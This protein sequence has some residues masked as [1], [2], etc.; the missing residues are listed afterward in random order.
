MASLAFAAHA[1]TNMCVKT[2]DGKVVKYDVENVTEVYYEETTETPS[3]QGVTVSGKEGIY[4]YVDLG[5]ESGTKWATYNV[6]ASKS[7]EY[8]DYFAWGETKPKEDYSWETYKWCTTVYAIDFPDTF[9]KY[10]TESDYG[11]VD[12]KNVLEAE[13]DAATANWGSAWRMPI[14]K[15]LGELLEG[16]DWEWVED[17]N[18][19]GVNGQ[20]GTSKANGATIFL[21]AAGVR[22][23]TDLY[24]AGHFGDYCS[25]SLDVSQPDCA[26]RLDFSDGTVFSDSRLRR[27]G[28]SVRA[29]LEE[30][31]EY[32]VNFYDGDSVLIESQKVREGMSA[33][34]VAAPENDGYKFVGWSDSSFVNVKENLKIYAL[35]EKNV[36]TTDQGVTVSGKVGIYTY[37]DL[38]LPSG[39]KWATYNVGATK[40]TEYGDYFAWGETKPKKD[41]NF[42]TYK[43]CKGS[44]RSMTKYCTKS[45]YGTVDNKKVL[46]AE[47]DAATANWGSAWRMPTW[48]EIKELLDGCSWE[49]VEDFNGSGVN[50]QLGTSKKNGSTIF[51]PAAVLLCD[52]NL[53]NAGGDGNYWSSSLDESYPIGAYILSFLDGFIVWDQDTRSF[54]LSVRAVLR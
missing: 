44:S 29:V 13:D 49:L 23:R 5:L 3:D 43:W 48:D 32:V 18:G 9:T 51:L 24:G 35:Y 47:D 40:P 42:D 33:N 27:D 20:L 22:Y 50:G 21:P 46:D 12:N 10:N 34:E 25:P 6:G 30:R 39:T 53:S 19:S 26:Y 38:G 11:T 14:A 8:G 4:T 45:D 28:R 16:C 41:Y 31:K 37:V 15:E 36:T 1:V 2:A 52:T 54:G 17:F 7:T